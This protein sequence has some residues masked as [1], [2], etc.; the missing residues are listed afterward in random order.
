MSLYMGQEMVDMMVLL[1]AACVSLHGAGA[2]G[3][4]DPGRR[5]LVSLCMRHELVDMMILAGGGLSLSTWSMS[6]WT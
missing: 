3:H 6:W 5:R 1:E 4:D 2:G